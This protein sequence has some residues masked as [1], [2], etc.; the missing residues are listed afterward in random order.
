MLLMPKTHE[1]MAAFC[2]ICG[3]YVQ[4]YKHSKCF[5]IIEFICTTCNKSKTIDS[6][7][8]WPLSYY[9]GSTFN[10]EDIDNLVNRLNIKKQ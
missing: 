4:Y 10:K 3:K 7:M 2:E 6:E 5:K 9:K 1:E 8:R